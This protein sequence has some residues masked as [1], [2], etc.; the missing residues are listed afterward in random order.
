M[1]LPTTADVDK[2]RLVNMCLVHDLAECIV[3]DI[4]PWCGVSADD[5]R[6]RETQVCSAFEPGP[7]T[8]K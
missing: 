2:Q 5:K 6:N 7:D 4:T 3:G 8:V 1:A